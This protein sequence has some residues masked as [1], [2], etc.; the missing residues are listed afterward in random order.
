MAEIPA[1]KVTVHMVASLD[2]FIVDKDG[3]VGWLETTDCYERGVDP[4]DPSR[5]LESVG[6]WV[7]GSRTYENALRLGWPYGDKPT[8]VLTNRELAAER[9]SVKFLSG[10]LGPL[11]ERELKPAF[12]SIWV[13]GGATLVKALLQQGLVDE[14]CMTVAPVII[15]DGLSFF[16]RVGVELPLHLNDV[17][18]YKSGMVE[19]TYQVEKQGQRIGSPR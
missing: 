5:F 4:E 11:F 16:D 7:I 2:G 17:K 14:I 19:L 18:A 1:S 3:G 10:D 8:F 13:C 9:T 12:S 15:G 6:C